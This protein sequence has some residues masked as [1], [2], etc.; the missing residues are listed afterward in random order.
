[1]G[2]TGFN[3]VDPMLM[4]PLLGPNT[5]EELHTDIPE[6]VPDTGATG[7]SYIMTFEQ[8]IQYHN[9]TSQSEST[10]KE[11]MD[12][13][14]TPSKSGIQQNLIQWA[15]VGFPPNYQVLSIALLR[16]SPCLDGQIRDMAS[17][18]SYLT[19]SDITTLVTN[20]QSNFL[21]IYFSYSVD[22]NIVN[23]HASKSPLA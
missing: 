16:P 1:M 9:T 20:F 12:F 13:I 2:D 18:I 21:G 6:V 17:Y 10:D 8:L 14:I 7:Q 4:F 19:G 23:L 3:G 11:T 22:G 15:S 5:L